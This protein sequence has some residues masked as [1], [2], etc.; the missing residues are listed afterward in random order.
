M[1]CLFFI[2]NCFILYF[3]CI[4]PLACSWILFI[5]GYWF[6]CCPSMLLLLKT[7]I[8]NTY[9]MVVQGIKSLRN[10][11]YQDIS[12]L[13]IIICIITV[14]LK[15]YMNYSRFPQVLT[16]SYK[17]YKCRRVSP[18]GP[19]CTQTH[20]LL[21]FHQS[22]WTSLMMFNYNTDF[23]LLTATQLLLR[24]PSCSVMK[25]NVVQAEV[26]PSGFHRPPTCTP[27]SQIHHT[28]NHTTRAY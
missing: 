17:M 5:L 6:F 22:L 16:W 18:G 28:N 2:L 8:V 9:I 23:K 19:V 20:P 14:I 26:W 12:V 3:K 10:T 1:Y 24:C 4:L 7:L 11:G 27:N 13:S 21:R 15:V 25:G